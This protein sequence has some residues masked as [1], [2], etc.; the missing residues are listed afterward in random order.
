MVDKDEILKDR[1]HYNQLVELIA[2]CYES[3]E[4][5]QL[6]SLNKKETFMQ[7]TGRDRDEEAHSAF[8]ARV[9]AAKPS[10]T[11]QTDHPVTY[12]LRL[13][14]KNAQRQAETSEPPVS[15]SDLFPSDLQTHI[16]TNTCDVE[17]V[18]VMTEDATTGDEQQG[19]ADI[20]VDCK[21]SYHNGASPFLVR[22]V[23]ENKIGSHEGKDQCKKYYEYYEIKDNSIIKRCSNIKYNIFAFLAPVYPD[24]RLSSEH[25]IKITYTELLHSVLKL[26]KLHR[27]SYDETFSVALDEYI[28]T[29]TS[30]KSNIAMDSEYEELAKQFFIKNKELI[31]QVIEVAAGDEVK[32][33]FNDAIKKRQKY[34]VTYEC[35]GADG[36]KHTYK[37]DD[38]PTNI[39]RLGI[40]MV[41]VLAQSGKTAD[42]IKLLFDNVFP[43]K[44]FLLEKED[45]K[46]EKITISGKDYWVATNVWADGAA[47]TKKLM[48]KFNEIEGM[49]YTIV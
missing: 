49:S 44:D 45:K 6:E 37:F 34:A 25:F 16:L 4:F 43:K 11:S 33:K 13:L 35:T 47:H 9:F 26:I 28:N 3:E 39:N 48:D 20:V 1:Q 40:Q 12:L 15:V 22:I 42:E 24:K 2:A 10:T 46:A 14:A 41:S 23:I 21:V 19:R 7:M 17:V 27:H 18:R 38:A 31:E 36:Q 30:P 8:L 32:A 29:I 5:H